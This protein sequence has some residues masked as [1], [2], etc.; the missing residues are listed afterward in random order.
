[1]SLEDHLRAVGDQCAPSCG[2]PAES[3]EAGQRNMKSPEAW[4][5][6]SEARFWEK[7]QDV[8][9]L[10]EEFV[11]LQDRLQQEEVKKTA[12]EAAA[13]ERDA[14][15]ASLKLDIMRIQSEVSS[16]GHAH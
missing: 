14:E 7:S 5:L 9:K 2:Q 11:Q 15:I 8:A 12:A 6:I 13:Q 3:S 1:V 4:L 16:R 10:R